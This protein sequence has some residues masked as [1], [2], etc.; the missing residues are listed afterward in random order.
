MACERKA[1]R[2]AL[3]AVSTILVVSLVALIFVLGV[4]GVA[5]N[6]DLW[7]K[8]WEHMGIDDETNMSREDLLRAARALV[9]YFEG[10]IESPQ[11]RVVIDGR[12]RALY[13]WREIRHLAD[14]RELYRKGVFLRNGLYVTVPG[15]AGLAFALWRMTQSDRQPR[16]GRREL[17]PVKARKTPVAVSDS[18]KDFV[19]FYLARI[20]LFAGVAVLVLALLL[21][22]PAAADF[23]DWWTAFHRISFSNDLWLL[24][25]STEWLVKM[26][27]LEFFSA[28]MTV[29]WR[30]V[31]VT[32][33]LLTLAGGL[34]GKTITLSNKLLRR[35]PRS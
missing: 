9:S 34:G 16:P 10:K 33:L 21:A 24:D 25:P 11:I 23:S 8:Q 18:L 6:V 5:L 29:L 28:I 19:R 22:V 2:V 14:V 35:P 31:V 32:G 15:L 17:S 4:Q 13:G 20:A 26:F 12:E 7:Q 30:R 3:A 1:P 27:P